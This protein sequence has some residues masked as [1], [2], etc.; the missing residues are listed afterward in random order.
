[1]ENS[2]DSTKTM[3]EAGS[4]SDNRPIPTAPEANMP[5]PNEP[6]AGTPP[7]SEMAVSEYKDGTYTAV[8]NYVSPGGPEEVGVS[9]T[10]KGDII[11]DSSI[12]VMAQ[13]PI[14]KDKQV[15]FSENY[16]QLVVGK[17]IDEVNVTKVSSSSLTPKGFMDALDKIE[18]DAKL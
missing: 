18:V 12:T 5:A 7:A 17:N 14:S 2:T 1:M 3:P 4:P 13:R 15:I 6:S 10:L 9:V 8:G 16:K 11:V